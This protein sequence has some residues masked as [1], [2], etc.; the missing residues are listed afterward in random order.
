MPIG[1]N[2][3]PLSQQK[4]NRKSRIGKSKKFKEI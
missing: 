4:S 2:T 3:S 1:I